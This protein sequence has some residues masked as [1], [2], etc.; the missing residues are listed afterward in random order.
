M[1]SL[2]RLQEAAYTGPSGTRIAF[3]FERVGAIVGRKT[4]AFEYPDRNGTFVQDNGSTGRRFPMRVFIDGGDYDIEADAFLELLSETGAG[5][6]EHPVYGTAKVVPFGQ[7]TRRDDLVNEVG[8]AVF[9]VSFFETTDTIFPNT[10]NDPASS[11]L[12]AVD[13]YNSAS[14]DEFAENLSIETETERVTLKDRY[15]A[16]LDSASSGLSAIAETSDDVQSQFNGVVDSINQSIDVLINDPLTL[17]FQTQIALQSPSRAA[18]AV[19]DRLDAYKNLLATFTNDNEP[20]NENELRLN[21]QYASDYL[22]GQV[23]STVNTTFNTRPEALNAATFILDE[24]DTFAVWRDESFNNVDTVDTGEAYQALQDAVAV[25]AG[26][27]VEISFTLKQE[28]R[29]TLDKEHTFVELC[30][31]LYGD[32]SDDS[33]NFFIDSNDLSGSEIIEIPRGRSIVYYI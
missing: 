16:L 26:S 8:Q 10:Q 28:R 14:A 2:D 11:V 9:E 20:A 12:S 32:V 3:N 15:L 5:T 13:V 17:A 29:I 25:A 31:E 23:L 7:I 30:G 6:L 18:A 4:S 33:L 27:L 1:S 21:D 22:I 19:Q 24:F